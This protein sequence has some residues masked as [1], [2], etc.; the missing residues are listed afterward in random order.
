M[1]SD[2][3]SF[4][5][6][7]VGTLYLHTSN[8]HLYI[9]WPSFAWTWQDIL[10]VSGSTLVYTFLFVAV[11]YFWWANRQFHFSKRP[12]DGSRLS[13]IATKADALRQLQRQRQRQRQRT[14]REANPD[15]DDDD[16]DDEDESVSHEDNPWGGFQHEHEN[17]SDYDTDSGSEDQE[18]DSREDDKSMPKQ[19]QT[20]FLQTLQ[21]LTPERRQQVKDLTAVVS[22]IEV[23]SYLSPQAFLQCLD[24]MQYVHLKH[25]QVLFDETTLD[26]SLY[27]VVSGQVQCQCQFTMYTSTPMEVEHPDDDDD[28]IHREQEPPFISFVAGNGDVVTSLLGM[29]AG[30]VQQSQK[31][32]LHNQQQQQQQQLLPIVPNGMAVRAVGVAPV[33]TLVKVSPDCFL[34]MLDKF[35]RDVHRIAQTIIAR[36]QRVILQTVCKSLGLQKEIVQ[37]HVVDPSNQP[38]LAPWERL[39]ETLPNYLPE[40]APQGVQLQVARDAA[41]VAAATIMGHDEHAG[42]TKIFETLHE[43]GTIVALPPGQI[44]VETGDLPHA[45]YLVLRGALQVGMHVTGPSTALQQSQRRASGMMHPN[46]PA[47]RRSIFPHK[48]TTADAESARRS[49]RSTKPQTSSTGSSHF[50]RLY[51]ST[52]GDLVGQLSCFTGD[53]SIVTVRN[54][55]EPAFLYKIPKRTYESIVAEYPTALTECVGSI[56]HRLG[57]PIVCLLDFNVEWVHVQASHSSIHLA[58]VSILKSCSHTTHFVIYYVA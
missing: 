32:T 55:W 47:T 44:L 6:C 52:A 12:K 4:G 16:D 5:S 22:Q 53:A 27:A 49:R 15:D 58:F 37:R 13:M 26:G 51:Q 25:G 30:L 24:Y 7:P 40:A 9:P 45:I 10:L 21:T 19:R 28:D 1:S 56:L 18:P 35:P 43:A 36:M 11:I 29:L 33:T 48:T 54:S 50:C 17:L 39:Q 14:A 3:C 23:F 31:R 42:I 20:P 38:L 46:P 2:T 34:D 8:F 57:S 41:W